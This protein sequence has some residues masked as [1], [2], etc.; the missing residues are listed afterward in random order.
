MIPPALRPWAPFLVAFTGLCELAGG[1]GIV[2]PWQ[3]VGAEGLD[4]GG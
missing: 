2:L 3:L 4:G 1:V